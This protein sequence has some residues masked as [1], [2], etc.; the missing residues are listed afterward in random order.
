[1][2]K[3]ENGSEACDMSAGDII[4]KILRVIAILVLGLFL[5]A[6]LVLGACFI[7]AR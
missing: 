7:L 2:G 4:G 6:G 1:V 3:L 5:F